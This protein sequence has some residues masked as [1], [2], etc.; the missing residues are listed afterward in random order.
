MK[1]RVVLEPAFILHRR[2]YSNTSLILELLTPNYGRVA[3]LAR[4]ARGLKSR[5][6]GTLEPFAPLL[7]SWSGHSNLK[8]LSKVE[9]NDTPYLLKGETLLC[10][11]YLNELLIR[12]LYHEDPCLRLFYYYQN[13]LEKL[14]NSQ[15]EATLR[16]FE[17]Q[18]LEELGYGLPLSCDIEM[19]S[20]LKADRFYRYLP[21]C[22]FLSCE[23]SKEKD[24]FSGKS[25]LALQ[26]ELFSDEDSLKE[27]KQLM[28]LTLGRLLGK[29]PLKS[30]ELLF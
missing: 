14:I 27:I 22:G 6:K 17:R 5:Y 9:L 29:K 18:L 20:P 11:F 19:K 24:I 4:S 10:A 23:K 25:L 28:R 7:V 16:C 12:L 8:S 13:A 15:L 21:D 2:P 1:K 30:R 3:S 26:K